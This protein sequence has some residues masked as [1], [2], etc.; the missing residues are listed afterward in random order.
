MEILLLPREELFLTFKLANDSGWLT[1]HR[2]IICEH[3]PG[4]LAGHIPE[5]YFLK[6]FEKAQIKGQTLTAY[7]RGK[8]QAEIKLLQSHQLCFRK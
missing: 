8:R 1:S 5:L 3:E 2:L 4:Q 6:E 7:F